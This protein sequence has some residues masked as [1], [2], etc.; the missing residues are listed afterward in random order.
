MVIRNI[1]ISYSSILET[2][3]FTKFN[4]NSR[5]KMQIMG[6]ETDFSASKTLKI[7]RT[8]VP[9]RYNILELYFYNIS[10]I[11]YALCIKQIFV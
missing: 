4:K 7:R 6:L 3:I 2:K 8:Y 10:C 1:F 11:V 5:L 9:K